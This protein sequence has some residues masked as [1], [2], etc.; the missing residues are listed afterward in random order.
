MF[1]PYLSG[2]TWR[3]DSMTERQ[4]RTE[5]EQLGRLAANWSRRLRR[6]RREPAAQL[7]LG[8]AQPAD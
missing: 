7:Q 1:N 6:P 3:L 4:R 8:A 2:T 5:E